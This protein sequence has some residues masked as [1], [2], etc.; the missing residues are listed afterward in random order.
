[1]HKYLFI[2][3][4]TLLTACGGGSS[5]DSPKAGI[6]KD[7]LYTCNEFEG[8]SSQLE[9]IVFFHQIPIRED[10]S[11]AELPF[12]HK[13]VHYTGKYTKNGYYQDSIKHNN[14]L[15][16]PYNRSIIAVNGSG[17]YA[18]PGRDQQGQNV[19][20]SETL[21]FKVGTNLYTS[22]TSDGNIYQIDGCT[23]KFIASPLK[24]IL[25]SDYQFTNSHTPYQLI[26]TASHQYLLASLKN[27][28]DSSY[29]FKL[30]L[31]DG[32][33]TGSE[34]AE[35]FQLIDNF[36]YSY[37]PTTDSTTP[38]ILSDGNLVSILFDGR[39]DSLHEVNT[40]KLEGT[41][42]SSIAKLDLNT[43]LTHSNGYTL[44]NLIQ[45]GEKAYLFVN[46]WGTGFDLLLELTSAD[47]E[48]TQKRTKTEGFMDL[49]DN[50]LTL[51]TEKFTIEYPSGNSDDFWILPFAPGNPKAL[52][53]GDVK[54][55]KTTTNEYFFI[56]QTKTFYRIDKE[57]EQV[58]IAH[59][60][61]NPDLEVISFDQ[62]SPQ[63]SRYVYFTQKTSNDGSNQT[64]QV[65]RFDIDTK[66]F[67]NIVTIDNIIKTYF[68]HG[69]DKLAL[70]YIDPTNYNDNIN[71]ND[72]KLDVIVDF[73]NGLIRP[74]NYAK[75]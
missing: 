58:H 68:I 19:N 12:D 72:K 43:F 8:K 67:S 29:T 36:N 9:D 6:K 30:I 4:L 65:S 53:Y 22:S 20:I 42:I 32:L 55:I 34:P 18:F 37:S 15:F 1:M 27:T 48:N 56:D 50:L 25:E 40:F 14:L 54:S 69:S 28:T 2:C 41:H 21:P 75:Q 13:S 61:T 64:Y 44:P 26:S 10:G 11:D 7:Q 39:S 51:N 62:G 5:D 71:D 31:L 74:I 52:N 47:V 16:Y 38:T 59:S 49:W 57:K 66:Q 35:T 73:E 45:V 17:D 70:K 24:S 33:A 63:W 3:T 60:I 23:L 46:E